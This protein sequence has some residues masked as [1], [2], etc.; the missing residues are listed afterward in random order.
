MQTAIL[1]QISLGA[2]AVH[3]KLPPCCSAHLEAQL[4]ASLVHFQGRSIVY[5]LSEFVPCGPYSSLAV[6]PYPISPV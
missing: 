6:C 1:K 3:G 2:G 4:K 5:H